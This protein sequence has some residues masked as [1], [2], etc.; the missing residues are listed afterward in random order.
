MPEFP[1]FGLR[2]GRLHP[3]PRKLAKLGP[4]KMGNMGP[5]WHI[6]SVGI[7]G[8]PVVLDSV[9]SLHEPAMEGSRR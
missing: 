6:S 1:E 2:D 3:N 7:F 8:G 5:F 9:L 4:P